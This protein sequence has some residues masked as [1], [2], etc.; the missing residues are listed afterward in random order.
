MGKGAKAPQNFATN[1]LPTYY[2]ILCWFKA[3][4]VWT[5]THSHMDSWAPRAHGWVLSDLRQCHEFWRKPRNCHNSQLATPY[6]GYGTYDIE[7]KIHSF[8]GSLI[9]SANKFIDYWFKIIRGS[10]MTTRNIWIL[11]RQ[12][13]LVTN[14]VLWRWIQSVLTINLN[15]IASRREI[16]VKQLVT[17]VSENPTNPH[18][19]LGCC[20]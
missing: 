13:N 10:P 17:R 9:S 16:I 19:C 3:S 11:W 5:P 18:F 14:Q 6:V 2:H 1:T 4:H 7:T 15:C 20:P 12:S 8:R